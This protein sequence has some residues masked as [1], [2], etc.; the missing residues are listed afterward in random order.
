MPESPEHKH[1]KEVLRDFF[2]SQYRVAINEYPDYG[3][4]NDVF[5]V[6]FPSLTMMVETIWTTSKQNFYRDLTIILSSDANIKIIIVNPKILEDSDFTRYFKK[7]K[8]SEERK[9]YSIIG[10][11]DWNFSDEESFLIDLKREIDKILKVRGETIASKIEEIKDMIYD[12]TISMAKI[13]S[14]CIDL[15]R[16]IEISDYLDWLKCEL[17]GYYTYIQDKEIHKIEDFP[18][19][20]YYRGVRG[21]TI[22][23]FGIGETYEQEIPVIISQPIHEIESWIE[24]ISPRGEIVLYLPLQKSLIEKI[25]KYG[26][27]DSSQKMPVMLPRSKL[28]R[29]ISS[30][31]TELHK[32]IEEIDEKISNT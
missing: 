9:G 3:F 20:P 13:I 32:F 4:E 26:P 22:F 7:I 24:N 15:S 11:L 29:I 1:I 14:K 31:R 16:K 17:Y 23:Y 28:E 6:I 5:S 8:I 30:L 12:S 21:K 19:K 25:R 2:S 18:G 10:M 27:F